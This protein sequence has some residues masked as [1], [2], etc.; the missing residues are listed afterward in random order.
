[1]RYKNTF[2]IESA[3][4]HY[5]DYSNPGMYFV[6]ICTQNFMEWF[7]VVNNEKMDLNKM[8]EIADSCWTKIPNHFPNVELDEY[9]IMPNHIHGIIGINDISRDADHN[10]SNYEMKSRTNSRRDVAC[11][12]ST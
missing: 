11:N 6:T 1:M 5:W 12:V 7:G 3:R 2:R 10:E 4:L 8:G 9:I